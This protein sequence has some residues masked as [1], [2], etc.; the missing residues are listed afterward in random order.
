MPLREVLFDEP[1]FEPL[2]KI[3]ATPPP[4]LGNRA[5]AADPR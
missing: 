2:L 1:A 5:F 3:V 4:W